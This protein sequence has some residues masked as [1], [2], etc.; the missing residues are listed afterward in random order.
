MRPLLFSTWRTVI[1]SQ[2]A[3]LET[4]DSVDSRVGASTAFV[5]GRLRCIVRPDKAMTIGH[6]RRTFWLIRRAGSYFLRTSAHFLLEIR[7]CC[8]AIVSVRR[9]RSWRLSEFRVVVPVRA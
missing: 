7:A 6:F 9:P 3:E 5:A 1:Y 4:T 8:D 2:E